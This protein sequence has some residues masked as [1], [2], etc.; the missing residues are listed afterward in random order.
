MAVFILHAVVF[1]QAYPFQHT[2]TFRRIHKFVPM[3]LGSAGVTFFFILSGFLIYWSNSEVRPGHKLSSYYLRRVTKIFP[4]H[5]T[6]LILFV[7]ASATISFSA[8]ERGFHPAMD[9]QRLELWVPNALLVHAR[10]GSAQWHECAVVVVGRGDAVLSVV[11][12]V[13]AAG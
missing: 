8:P 1:I 5:W 12:F 3:Q 11:S 13:C 10:L 7:P 4:T 2:E 9:F 6:A